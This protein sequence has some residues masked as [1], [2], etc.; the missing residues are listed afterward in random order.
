MERAFDTY[1]KYA[2]FVTTW[3][4]A[5]LGAPPPHVL[6]LL[7]AATEHVSIADRFANGFNNPADFFEWFMD[8]AKAE[9]YLA[10]VAGTK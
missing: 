9:A 5:M 3:T 7:G 4:S 2:S 1:W 10:E 6:Q 8:P